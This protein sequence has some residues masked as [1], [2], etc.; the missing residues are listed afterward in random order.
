M[1][2][3]IP[4]DCDWSCFDLHVVCPPLLILAIQYSQRG[5][6]DQ[7]EAILQSTLGDSALPENCTPLTTRQML[8]LSAFWPKDRS[9]IIQLKR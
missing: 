3:T 8:E 6:L 4:Q 9:V 7:E 5:N 2:C 1:K